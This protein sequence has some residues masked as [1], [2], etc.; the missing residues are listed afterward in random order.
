MVHR[1][2]E[3][4]TGFPL[5]RPRRDARVRRSLR[6]DFRVLACQRRGV[7]RQGAGQS[8]RVD[9]GQLGAAGES[10][11]LDQGRRSRKSQRCRGD[12]CDSPA[13]GKR[14]GQGRALLAELQND[15]SGPRTVGRE[16]RRP[17]D[18]HDR[19]AH[20]ENHAG[21][22]RAAQEFSLGRQY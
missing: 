14:A 4:F 9:D 13:G 17:R 22:S 11:I 1:P 18:R 15:Q 21:R 8:W 20:A 19:R 7:Y 12:G 16:K 10:C 6:A 2:A 5:Q 3:W